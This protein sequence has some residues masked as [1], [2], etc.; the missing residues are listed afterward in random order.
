M[1]FRDS[2]DQS[3]RPQAIGPGGPPVS[4]R[5]V[6][7]LAGSW[8]MTVTAV[9]RTEAASPQAPGDPTR[10]VVFIHAGSKGAKPPDH[11]V[12]TIAN[13]LAKLGYIVRA[14]DQE[15]D[16]VGGQGVDYFSEQDLAFAQ[17]VA[18]IVNAELK[19]SFEKAKLPEPPA[20]APRKQSVK[21]PAGYLG[22]WLF[23]LPGQ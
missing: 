12:D 18:S 16:V 7:T 8:L 23:A 19:A 11:I 22:V 13:D 6:A 2:L 15:Q 21:N 3:R 20:L 4:R 5:H 14:P 10:S 9:A 1:M 17:H